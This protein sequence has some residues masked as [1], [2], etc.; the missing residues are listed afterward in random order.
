MRE[1]FEIYFSETQNSKLKKKL[2]FKIL[3]YWNFLKKSE[4]KSN[5]TYEL[6]L[7]VTSHSSVELIIFGADVVMAHALI[8]FLLIF[9]QHTWRESEFSASAAKKLEYRNRLNAEADIRLLLSSIKPDIKQLVKN[10]KS[11][12]YTYH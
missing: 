7:K 11:N 8:I 5:K 1:F 3:F 9:Q 10:K 4:N 6:F 12:Y 2:W